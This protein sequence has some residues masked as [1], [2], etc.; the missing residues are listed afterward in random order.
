MSTDAKS[1][2]FEVD[3]GPTT[4]RLIMENLRSVK[5]TDLGVLG[6]ILF[7][8]IWF[9]LYTKSRNNL[10]LCSIQF[11]LSCYFIYITQPLNSFMS[12]RW[13][14]FGM[15]TNYFDPNCV[16]VFLFWALPLSAVSAL[17]ILGLFVDLCKSIAVHRYFDSIISREQ[18]LNNEKKKD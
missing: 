1:F 9:L 17:I 2:V 3:A 10:T 12:E 6:M 18:N 14:G 4:L 8:V 5:Y 11:M 13:D 7:H 16:F 15:S